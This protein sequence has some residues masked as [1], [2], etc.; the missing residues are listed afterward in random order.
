VTSLMFPPDCTLLP[1]SEYSI[2]LWDIQTGCLVRKARE[3][4]R[5]CRDSS[6]FSVR[7]H[8]CVRW[9]RL[10]EARIWD[11]ESQKS[12]TM[13][14]FHQYAVKHIGCSP[15]GSKLV[16]VSLSSHIFGPYDDIR[17]WDVETLHPE[18]NNQE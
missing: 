1:S 18:F 13:M 11:V 14:K 12:R 7:N 15:D 2:M 9:A 10:S 6:L 4:L 16:S 3:A 17:G 5:L 8:A